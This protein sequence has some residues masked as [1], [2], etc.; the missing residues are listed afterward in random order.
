VIALSNVERN[1]VEAAGSKMCRHRRHKL[2]RGL[3][4]NEEKVCGRGTL[5]FD[6]DRAS[7]AEHPPEQ[8]LDD[9]NL[10]S[11][12]RFLFSGTPHLGAES[13]SAKQQKKNQAENHKGYQELY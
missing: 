6:N 4:P 3:S 9:Q 5:R 1:L 13:Q 2:E 8:T 11:V 10:L 7:F 12:D